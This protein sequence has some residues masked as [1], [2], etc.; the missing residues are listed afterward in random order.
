MTEGKNRQWILNARPAG[1]LTGKE[2]R[3]NQ[4]SIPQPS[5]GQVLVRTLWLS[6]DPAQRTWMARDTYRPK[7]ALGEVM[8]SLAVGQVLES[9][10]PDFKPGDLLRGD[11]GWQDYAVTDGQGFGG[12]HKVPP[13]VPANLALSLFGL[14]GPTA[15]FG[16]TEIGQVKAGETVV[17]SGAAGAVGSVAGQIA[18]I[19][20]C[21]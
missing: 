19:K 5:P 2:F 18:K 10:H 9:R 4:A 14:T 20:G 12:L 8:S 1:K 15:Y 16:I 6:F 17:V 11:F 13:G 3:W 21:R 7:V